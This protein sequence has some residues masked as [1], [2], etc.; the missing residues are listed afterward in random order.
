MTVEIGVK[1]L[2]A[3]SI[4]RE[5]TTPWTR[6][7]KNHVEI[8]LFNFALQNSSLFF[9]FHPCVPEVNISSYSGTENF[10]L[11]VLC[12]RREQEFLSFKF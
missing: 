3:Q 9:T 11:S 7:T 10:F 6:V 1:N 2:P 4:S 12:S 8:G 5:V